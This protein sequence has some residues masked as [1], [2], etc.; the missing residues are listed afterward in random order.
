MAHAPAH[1]TP[2][3]DHHE[4]HDHEFFIPPGSIWPP[5]SCLGAG[6]MM[7]GLLLILHVQPTL[8]GKLTMGAGLLLTVMAAF[9]WFF[10]LIK[11]ARERGFGRGMVPLVLDL[12]NRYGMIFFIASELMFFAAFFAAY[13]Y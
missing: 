4:V 8:Y 6:I 7:F 5:L 12:A 3:G 10:L 1:S 11:E 9:Q 2:H 13:F